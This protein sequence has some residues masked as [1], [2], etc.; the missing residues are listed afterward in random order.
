[1]AAEVH[2]R[3]EGQGDTERMAV[4]AFAVGE[5]RDGRFVYVIEDEGDGTGRAVRRTVTVGALKTI[6]YNNANIEA[7]N[8]DGGEGDDAFTVTPT[9]NTPPIFV[10]GGNPIAAA[11]DTLTV[12]ATGLGVTV[13]AGPENDAGAV[14]VTGLE[15]VSF[16]QI[17][18]VVIDN[19]GAAVI[20]G[21]HADDQITVLGTAAD[22]AGVVSAAA[23]A[24][25][26]NAISPA[27]TG[28]ANSLSLLGFI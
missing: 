22:S 26:P 17:E 5:D 19:A 13:H 27:S 25:A 28:M 16:D 20:C 7:L 14:E 15:A 2:F 4:P 11:G 10:N 3:F 6:N 1:M 23:G 8:V 18:G 24:T 9:V 12:D 21:T